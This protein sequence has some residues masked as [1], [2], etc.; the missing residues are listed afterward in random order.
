MR[1]LP[2]SCAVWLAGA[3]RPIPKGFEIHHRNTDTSDNRW[4]N[5]FC[6]FGKD[7]SKLH[8]GDLLDDDKTPF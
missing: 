5:L 4:L 3:R 7:H 2:I 6:L 1:H 8:N